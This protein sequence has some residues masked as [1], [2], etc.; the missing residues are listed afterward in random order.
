MTLID[1]NGNRNSKFMHAMICTQSPSFETYASPGMH[2]G[3]LG[4]FRVKL[5]NR[6]CGVSGTRNLKN[7]ARST[8]HCAILQQVLVE[9]VNAERQRRRAEVVEVISEHVHLKWHVRKLFCRI[10]FFPVRKSS[11]LRYLKGTSPM[12]GSGPPCPPGKSV[13]SKL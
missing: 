4:K 12:P 5:A 3:S 2:A 11:G 6:V 9:S 10:Q 7:Y 13:R 1:G 8:L